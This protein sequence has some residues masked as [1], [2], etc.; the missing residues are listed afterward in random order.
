MKYLP[1]SLYLTCRP[2]SGPVQWGEV[3]SYKG[4]RNPRCDDQIRDPAPGRRGGVQGVVSN[5]GIPPISLTLYRWRRVSA[6]VE[7]GGQ[8]TD[9]RIFICVIEVE[10]WRFG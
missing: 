10:L 2:F 5:A 3:Y 1:T 8:S 7:G 4:F 6:P 9:A